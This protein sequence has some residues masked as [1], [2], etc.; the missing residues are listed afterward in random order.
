LTKEQD[1]EVRVGYVELTPPLIVRRVVD[2]TVAL[3]V[4]PGTLKQEGTL[5][6]G[7]E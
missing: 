2:D 7:D 5:A 1:S 4:N 6:V 3:D